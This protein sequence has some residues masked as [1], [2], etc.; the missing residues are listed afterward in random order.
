MVSARAPCGGSPVPEV[1]VAS[2]NQALTLAL[3]GV[4][5]S[6][7]KWGVAEAA[8]GLSVLASAV[9]RANREKEPVTKAGAEVSIRHG[10][11]SAVLW[12]GLKESASASAAIALEVA[13]ITISEERQ[14][15]LSL[16]CCGLLGEHALHFL[17]SVFHGGEPVDR[18][19]VA[20]AAF[21]RH[22]TGLLELSGDSRAFAGESGPGV[23]AKCGSNFLEAK[24]PTANQGERAG[25]LYTGEGKAPILS[26]QAC[27]V[28]LLKANGDRASPRDGKDRSQ[29]GVQNPLELVKPRASFQVGSE[30]VVDTGL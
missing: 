25:V 10:G 7:V 14:H 13:S 19:P 4:S 3:A 24:E 29:S 22:G 30:K 21:N 12:C 18:C 20:G 26:A 17:N 1:I 2:I 6:A 28:C 27:N 16:L 5:A 11:A 15:F 8:V 9:R 23:D